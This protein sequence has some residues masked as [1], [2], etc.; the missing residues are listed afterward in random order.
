MQQKSIASAYP[1]EEYS[2]PN[3]VIKSVAKPR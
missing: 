1:K 3:R 2:I